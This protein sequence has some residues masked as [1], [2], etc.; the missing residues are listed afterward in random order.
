[1]RFSEAYIPSMQVF[2]FCVSSYHRRYAGFFLPVSV[3]TID[4]GFRLCVLAHTIDA[5][6]FF[7]VLAHTV[8]SAFSVCVSST[9]QLTASIDAHE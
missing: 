3:H 9:C 7:G 5:V 4:A 8:D 2:F 1:M 6:I